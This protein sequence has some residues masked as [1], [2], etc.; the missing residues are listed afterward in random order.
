MP[1]E[2]HEYDAKVLADFDLFKKSRDVVLKA[3]EE[4][5]A[6]GKI[7]SS[8]EASLSLTISDSATYDLLAK[9]DKD[10]ARRLF[11]V[12]DLTLNKGKDGSVSVTKSS[13]ALCDRCRNYRGDVVETDDHA[14][15]CERC[16]NV[17]EGKE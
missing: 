6:E 1:K 9:M 10:E 16:R 8:S 2:S 15:L 4:A 5:R 7:G 17:L 11:M 14:H 12:A 3:L 13:D